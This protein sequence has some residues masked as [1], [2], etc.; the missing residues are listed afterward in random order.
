MLTSIISKRMHRW[1]LLLAVSA[2]L[3]ACSLVQTTYNQLPRLVYFWLDQQVDFTPEQSDRVS[4][5]LNNWLAWHRQT[6]LA[7]VADELAI[8]QKQVR[9][10]LDAD[11]V[12]A[13][14]DRIQNWTFDW[15]A[16]LNAD[17]TR[18]GLDL[19]PAQIANLKKSYAK[20]NATWREDW[21]EG[22]AQEQTKRRAKRG[23]EWAQRLYGDLSND[24]LKWLTQS[25]RQSAFDPQQSFEWRKLRQ[26]RMLG[27]LIN[28]SEQAPPFDQA[29]SQ[30][31]ATV[32]LWRQ[33][34]D[35]DMRASQ[36]R[37]I[38]YNCQ[39]IADFHNQTSEAQRAHAAK[40]LQG[41]EADA[42]ALM[43][44]KK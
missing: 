14:F 39:A 42:R 37:M 32:Q 13:R 35:P 31:A 7:Q 20:S 3:A 44:E 11:G 9:Q 19:S 8:W 4:S 33:L 16:R 38:R 26:G 34:P 5:A 12:C 25:A 17:L 22:S 30:M 29:Q 21:M 2:S 10:P 15:I 24:Q 36:E 28:W 27:M 1:I 18:L 6:Q 41:Y 43:A 23:R 40:V